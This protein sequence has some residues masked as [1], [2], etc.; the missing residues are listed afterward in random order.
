MAINELDRKWPLE[1]TDVRGPRCGR[2]CRLVAASSYITDNSYVGS[3]DD[4]LG[5]GSSSNDAD[6]NNKKTRKHG[7]D[8]E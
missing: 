2:P 7:I 8:L 5:P 3:S 4:K 6:T 1:E